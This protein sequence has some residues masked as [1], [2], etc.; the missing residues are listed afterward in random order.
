MT[1]FLRVLFFAVLVGELFILTSPNV[2]LSLTEAEVAATTTPVAP[3]VVAGTS[4]PASPSQPSTIAKPI[5]PTPASP[6]GGRPSTG[7][8]AP[9]TPTL[10]LPASSPAPTPSTPAPSSAPA[11]SSPVA[12]RNITVWM[13]GTDWAEAVVSANNNADK[14]GEMSPAWYAANADG[15]VSKRSGVLVNDPTLLANAKRN[16]Q[17]VVPLVM[18]VPGTG[19]K[20]DAIIKIF[21]DQKLREKHVAALVKVAVDNNYD[22]L[23]IDY[24]SIPAEN[25]SDLATFIEELS[26]AM[27]KE[28]KMVAVSLETQPSTSV[29][30][31]WERIGKAADNIRLM[32]YGKQSK[33]PAPI[34][35]VVW[36]KARLAHMLKVIPKEKVTLGLPLYCLKW[37]EKGIAGSSTWKKLHAT[38]SNNVRCEDAASVKEKVDAAR[39]LGVEKF[40]FW[41]IGGEDP[42]IWQKLS[43]R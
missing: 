12:S 18:S 26:V 8:A 22:G 20:T 39:T 13:Q 6:L 30:P 7:E 40:A 10:P 42:A 16:G 3:G 27:H 4:T 28:N 43:E 33:I 15:S 21:K 19:A 23:D 2:Q 17:K 9:T 25:L 14:V 36:A 35:D 38:T 1:K 11:P 5:R 29:L 24:E 41:R 32:G 37:N 31:A 34:S